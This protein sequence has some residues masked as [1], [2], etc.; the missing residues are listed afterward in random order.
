[1]A[2]LLLFQVI[3]VSH[4]VVQLSDYEI[5]ET[6][7]PSMQYSS[8]R[9][10]NWRMLIK[11]IPRLLIALTS[12]EEQTLCYVRLR[13]IQCHRVIKHQLVELRVEVHFNSMRQQRVYLPILYCI[14]RTVVQYSIPA[15][16]YVSRRVNSI[17]R[18]FSHVVVDAHSRAN[19]AKQVTKG[20]LFTPCINGSRPCNW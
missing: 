10:V 13:G 14:Q 6:D 4:L 17:G 9:T 11:T 7:H 18:S 2:N 1:M 5:N 12:T 8:N 15:C 3:L 20:Q 16:R 19:E